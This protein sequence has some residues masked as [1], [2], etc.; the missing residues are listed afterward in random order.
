[1][2]CSSQHRLKSCV[3]QNDYP[4]FQYLSFFH[5]DGVMLVTRYLHKSTQVIVLNI[6]R[7]LTSTC[8]NSNFLM[9]LILFSS[10]NIYFSWSPSTF[11]QIVWCFQLKYFS[12]FSSSF[13]VC[14]SN[15]KHQVNKYYVCF[16]NRYHFSTLLIEILLWNMYSC[17]LW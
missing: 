5:Q 17:M 11:S 14:L 8:H 10:G 3:S 12:F 6:L 16:L 1:M 13:W 7:S 15:W 2:D 9:L 4:I